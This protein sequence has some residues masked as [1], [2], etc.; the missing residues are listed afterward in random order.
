MV[1]DRRKSPGPEG[2]GCEEVIPRLRHVRAAVI[3]AVAALRHQNCEL[4]ED[5]ACLL[6]RC[7]CDPLDDQIRSLEAVGRIRGTRVRVV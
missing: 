2:G 5:V 1:R 3:V 6:Q 4:D 7:V